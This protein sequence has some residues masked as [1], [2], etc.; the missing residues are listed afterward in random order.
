MAFITAADGQGWPIERSGGSSPTGS[1]P[2][3]P[4]SIAARPPPR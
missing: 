1:L 2:E 4:S 3:D